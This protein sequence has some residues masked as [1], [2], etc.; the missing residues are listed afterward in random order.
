MFFDGSPCR[1]WL[2][3][4]FLQYGMLFSNPPQL[5]QKCMRN[6]LSCS[7]STSS[8]TL[9]FALSACGADSEKLIQSFQEC[10]GCARSHRSMPTPHEQLLFHSRVQV[11]AH[12]WRSLWK[13]LAAG[14]CSN[15]ATFC[16]ALVCLQQKTAQQDPGCTLLQMASGRVMLQDMLPAS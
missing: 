1:K 10:F 8:L 3:Y 12:S 13:S 7:C 2:L 15:S 9:L 4:W 11:N 14:S 6:T 5:L 16:L